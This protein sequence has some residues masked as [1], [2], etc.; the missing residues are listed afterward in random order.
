MPALL[1]VAIVFLVTGASLATLPQYVHAELGYGADV[2]SAVAASK[3]VSAVFSRMWAGQLAD[4]RGPMTAIW[5]VPRA[6]M[7]LVFSSDNGLTFS[8][9]RHL[10]TGSG[11]CL[12]NN[13]K[14]GLNREYSY[15]SIIEGPDGALHIAYT[16][17]RRAIKY[18][19]L[20]AA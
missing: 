10:E 9:P 5:G 13:S 17:H 18:V 15:P 20:A 14:D 4:G 8:P 2:V 1:A 11:Y 16:Y 6:P 19:R 3:F 12:T 7:S